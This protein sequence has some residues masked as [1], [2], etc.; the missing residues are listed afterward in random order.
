MCVIAGGTLCGTHVTRPIVVGGAT[1][2]GAA[3]T[4]LYAEVTIPNG[5]TVGVGGAVVPTGEIV[6]VTQRTAKTGVTTSQRP[7]GVK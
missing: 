1:L 5:L 7:S 2:C 6:V 3:D 4:M